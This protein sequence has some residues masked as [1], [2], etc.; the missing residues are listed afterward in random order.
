MQETHIKDCFHRE[1]G[2]LDINRLE[3]KSLRVKSGQK[4]KFVRHSTTTE[5][6]FSN[7]E[8]CL[9]MARTKALPVFEE[10]YR[11]IFYTQLEKEIYWVSS[12]KS[13]FPNVW[14][15]NII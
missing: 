1:S 13:G 6:R 14:L 15:L 8:L 4:A 7:I 3:E 5:G 10:K 11:L 12:S 2:Y 9:N